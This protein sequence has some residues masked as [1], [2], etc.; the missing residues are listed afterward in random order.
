MIVTTGTL[1]LSIA[2]MEQMEM[3]LRA[4]DFKRKFLSKKGK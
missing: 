3:V 2:H 4:R 1:D